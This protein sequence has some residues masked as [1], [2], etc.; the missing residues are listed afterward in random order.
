[1]IAIVACDAKWGIGCNGKLQQHVSADL[2]RFKAMTWGKVVIYGRNTLDTFP[3]KKPLPGRYNIIL[4]RRKES[5]CD[6]CEYVRSI[7][8]L[9]QCLRLLKRE[10]FDD[11]DFVVIGG[12]I[13]YR[14]LLPYCDTV[15]VT[16]F[17]EA[18]EADCYF[19]DLDASPDWYL[20]TCGQ[21]LE[22]KGIRFRYMVYRRQS[23]A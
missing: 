3:G 4:R 12:A 7:D 5:S 17:A 23:I 8:E 2:R 21:W 20:D 13:V 15:H 18:Y 6:D 9:M 19:P 16:Q 14:Q 22:E 1:M 10:G 11:D